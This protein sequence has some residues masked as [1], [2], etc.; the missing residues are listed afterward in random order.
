MERGWVSRTW[1]YKSILILREMVY[2]KPMIEDCFSLVSE[3]FGVKRKRG[4]GEDEEREKR[5]TAVPPP[6]CLWVIYSLG[7]RKK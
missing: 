2:V 4:R 6:P 1:D 5:Q 3:R 7:P